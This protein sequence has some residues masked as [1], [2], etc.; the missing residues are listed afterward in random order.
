[1]QDRIKTAIEELEFEGLDVSADTVRNLAADRDRLTAALAAK[2]AECERLRGALHSIASLEADCRYD[3]PAQMLASAA[4]Q[5]AAA[6][7][8]QPPGEGGGA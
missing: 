5:I 2:E 6:A 4:Y 7:L 3:N 1:M 8:A